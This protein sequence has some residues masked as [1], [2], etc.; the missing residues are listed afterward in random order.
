MLALARAL[1]GR[2]RLLMVDELS[3]GL[4]PLIVSRLLANLREL[5]DAG[6][7]IIVVEQHVEQVLRVADRVMVLA[8][9]RVSFE[10]VPSDLAGQRDRLAAAYL[11]AATTPDSHP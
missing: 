2:P 9:G 8:R 6:L 7:G 4:A 11:G 3:L 10:G 5:A 1:I